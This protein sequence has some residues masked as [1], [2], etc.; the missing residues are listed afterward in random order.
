MDF[1]GSAATHGGAA[2]TRIDTH[3]AAVFLAGERA[4]KIKRAVRFPFLDF[5]RWTSARRPARPRLRSIA[6]SRRQIYR[7]VVAI[8]R[9][10][11]GGL[12]IGGGGEPVEW[13]VEMRRFDETRTLD[14]LAERGADRR[15]ARRRA[16][17]RGGARR[18]RR[19]R[20]RR[21]DFADAL[22][23]VIAQNDAELRATPE[24]FAPAA[25]EALS[26]ATPARSNAMRAAA[27]RARARRA[28]AALPRRS[29][30]RQYR[31]HRRPAGAV[32]RHRVRSE[33]RDRRRALRSRFPADGPDRAQSCTAPPISCS[34]AISPKR[35]AR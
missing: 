4:L 34:T 30:S 10:P 9:R 16:R 35:A 24:L 1:L 23:E 19:R 5:R 25:V 3:A 13:A 21:C 12:A 29:A 6:P 17:P 33:D 31:A 8:T 27:R 18:M 28:G 11:D 26:R 15:R 20:L 22:A 7:G 2:V 32:R 14:H